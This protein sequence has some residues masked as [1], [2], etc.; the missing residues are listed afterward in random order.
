MTEFINLTPHAINIILENRTVVLEPSGAV[1][2]VDVT[3]ESTGTI[4]GVPIT[5]NTYG[6]VTG[7]PEPKEGRYY[8]VPSLVAQAVQRGDVLI[9]N[10]AVRDENGRIIGCRSLARV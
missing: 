4:A 10:D 8:V 6:T 5:R 2:R 3:M 7:L 1:A 9:P